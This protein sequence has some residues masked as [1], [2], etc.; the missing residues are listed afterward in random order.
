MK[1]YIGFDKRERLAWD[2]AEYSIL[3]RTDPR[4]VK[5]ESLRLTTTPMLKRPIEYRTNENGVQQMWCP[6]SNA[7]MSTAF[8]VSRFAVPFLQEKGG[9]AL[10]MDCDMICLADIKELFALA[11]PQ[12]AV[13]VVKHF[14]WP[15]EQ[16]HDAGQLQTF[17]ERKNWSSLILWNLDHPGNKRLTV[18]DL[19]TWPGRDLHAFKWLKDE[20]IGALP[21]E[22]NYLVGVNDPADL[23]KQKMIHYT[24]GHP[25]WPG[26]EPQDTDYIFNEELKRFRAPVSV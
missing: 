20:E 22:W 18:E 13:Q 21:Q 7:P 19:N 15:T 25:A 24:N 10:G 2:L 8:A 4:R 3:S 5:I 23:R 16:Y 1:I 11:D 6:I 14:H 26:W 12:F 17:Y 9:L